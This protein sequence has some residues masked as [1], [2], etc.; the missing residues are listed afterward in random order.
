MKSQGEFIRAI[1]TALE[2]AA[3]PYM[4]GGSV[5]SSIHGPHRSTNDVDIVIAPTAA[6][7]EQFL[8]AVSD[9]YVSRPAALAAFQRC[10]MFNV[11]DAPSGHKADLVFL[12]PRSYSQ[13]ELSRRTRV[14]FAGHE[15]YVASPEDVI[16]SKLEWSKMGESERQFRDAANVALTKW[17]SLDFAYL[18]NWAVELDVVEGLNELKRQVRAVLPES[19]NPDP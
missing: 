15:I 9:Y 10:S 1:C 4:I 19:L 13:T 8:G 2:Q 16:L 18:E 12:K 11:I 14:E 7:L 17:H 6:Q 5:A 3:I